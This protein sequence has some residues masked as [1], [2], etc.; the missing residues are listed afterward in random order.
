MNF[1]DFRTGI[2]CIVEHTHTNLSHVIVISWLPP[3]NTSPTIEIMVINLTR[4][5]PCSNNLFHF[6]RQTVHIRTPI[7]IHSYYQC[8]FSVKD[9]CV[10]VVDK[11]LHLWMQILAAFIPVFLWRVDD[12]LVLDFVAFLENLHLL[13]S[14][15][16]HNHPHK[17]QVTAPAHRLSHRH[18][19]Q[20]FFLQSANTWTWI[21]AGLEVQDI[22]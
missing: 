2:I 20:T 15:N 19:F 16:P 11:L 1:G 18:K 4:A 7:P 17:L 21:S 6:F 10:D 12:R 14:M 3:S 22:N 5:S 8:I 9:R 13:S